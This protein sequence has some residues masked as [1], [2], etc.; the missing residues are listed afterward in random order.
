[1]GVNTAIE[2]CDHTFNPWIGCTKVSAGCANCYAEADQDKFRGRVKWGKG[3]PRSRTSADYWKQPL[4]WNKAAAAAG[5]F[6]SV[7]CASLADVFDHEVCFTWLADLLQLIIATPN[8]DWL[9]LTKRPE[10]IVPR[11]KMIHVHYAKAPCNDSFCAWIEN[12]LDGNPPHNVRLGTT[13]ENQDAADIRIPHLLRVPARIHFLSCEPLLGPVDIEQ[14]MP[15]ADGF[16]SLPDTGPWHIDDGAPQIDWVIAGAESGTDARPSHPDWV[17][18]LRDQCILRDEGEAPEVAFLFKQWGEWLPY[19][20]EQAPFWQGQHGGIID[21]HN[22]PSNI[23]EHSRPTGKNSFWCPWVEC[24]VVFRKAGKHASG[25][26]LD[27]KLH[28]AFP[29][30]KGSASA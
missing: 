6:P 22:F 4:R 13:V 26:L 16:V 10:N 15:S 3:Q 28:N 11:L 9:L 1:M 14:Y 8:L 25:R 29:S 23:G 18:S 17:R 2:W 7:F 5:T 19:E 24:D 12:W 27:G 20:P 30:I 21:S